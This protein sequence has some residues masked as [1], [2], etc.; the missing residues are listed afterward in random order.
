M[1]DELSMPELNLTETSLAE[2]KVSVVETKEVE[3]LLVENK[4]RFVLFPIKYNDMWEMYK[5]HEAS[6]WTAEE[7]GTGII[8]D[9]NII[10][11]TI[12]H[13][14]DALGNPTRYN[15]R[16]FRNERPCEYCI[17]TINMNITKMKVMPMEILYRLCIPA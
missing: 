3:P 11:K 15:H 4:Q 13:T 7:I 17:M 2:T 6:F 5:K 9:F 12:Q 16:M 1:S 8:L 14:I 10:S